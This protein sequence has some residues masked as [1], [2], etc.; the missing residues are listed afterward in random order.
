MTL[1]RS[2]IAELLL[3]SDAKNC[4]KSIITE[5]ISTIELL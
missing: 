3:F 4:E 5:N 1:Y 2:E